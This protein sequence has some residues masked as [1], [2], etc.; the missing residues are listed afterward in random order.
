MGVLT[1]LVILSLTLAFSVASRNLATRSFVQLSSNPTSGP[2]PY[3]ENGKWISCEQV[4]VDLSALRS[5]QPLIL[6]NG[7]KV[8]PFGSPQGSDFGSVTAVYQSEDLLNSMTITFFALGTNEV[9]A[10]I[11]EGDKVFNL[12]PCDQNG[13]DCHVLAEKDPDLFNVGKATANSTMRDLVLM[14]KTALE[15]LTDVEDRQE[16]GQLQQ[17]ADGT[18]IATIKIYYTSQFAEAESNVHAY[19]SNMIAQ[20]NACFKNSQTTVRLRLLC[21]E[22]LGNMTEHTDPEITLLEF[23]TIKGSTANLRGTADFAHLLVQEIDTGICGLAYVGDPQL[24][25]GLSKR[26]CAI[27]TYAFSHELGHNL[28]CYH[29]RENSPNADPNDYGF[30]YWIP[31]TGHRTL[32]A[33]W[34]VFFQSLLNLYSNPELRHEGIRIGDAQND[35]ARRIREN[36]PTFANIG[37]DTDTCVE[38]VLS[39]CN[40]LT[41]RFL[42]TGV[43]LVVDYPLT[44]NYGNDEQCRWLFRTAPGRRL[45]MQVETMDIETH[46]R[47][48]YDMLAFFGTTLGNLGFCGTGAGRIYQSVG[49]I[50]MVRFT[51]DG[52]VNGG[53]FRV[54]VEAI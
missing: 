35:C 37:S 22:Q 19:I 10:V 7:D 24:P 43:S 4:A 31:G 50:F 13:R 29:D 39:T 38:N 9:N 6:P 23:A 47:C 27:S 52:S 26:D 11:H 49:I 14:T 30:G 41:Y 5:N 36:V 32:M 54:R 53:G 40:R 8:S 46:D 48:L 12:A 20:A 45:K 44:G 21:T 33:Y 25:F 1:N 3:C 18:Y 34:H 42:P 51:S 2:I 17:D 15:R 28:G 16:Q